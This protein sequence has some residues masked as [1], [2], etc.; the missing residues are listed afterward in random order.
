MKITITDKFKTLFQVYKCLHKLPFRHAIHIFIKPIDCTRYVEF[1][2]LLKFLA[3]NNKTVKGK[4]LD[5]SSP[6]IMSYILSKNAHVTKTDIYEEEKKFIKPSSSLTFEKADATNLNYQDNT[7]DF[8]YSISVIEHIYEKYNL[9]ISEMIRVCKPGGFIYIS[10]PVSAS[11]ME[12]WVAHTIY[13]D[14]FKKNEKVF[15]QYRFDEAAIK[16]M[17]SQISDKNADVI[18]SH[19]FWESK[20]GLYDECVERLAK[21]HSK[22]NFLWNAALNFWYGLTLLETESKPFS[23]AKSFGNISFVIQKR[24]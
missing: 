15:F 5:V 18:S 21:K 9:A 8:V 12:E 24:E 11:F 10:T 6:F 13:S 7:F 4:V 1:P 17:F 20:N 2:Y 3:Q 19:V 14:Q 16:N 22:I 23:N